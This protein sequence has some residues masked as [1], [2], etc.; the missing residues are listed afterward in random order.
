MG[1]S[2]TR[3]RTHVSCTSRQIL[4]HWV[5]REAPRICLDPQGSETERGTLVCTHSKHPSWPAH[6]LFSVPRFTVVAPSP[7]L[8]FCIIWWLLTACQ[9]LYK[10]LSVFLILKITLQRRISGLFVRLFTC[11]HTKEEGKG[12]EVQGGGLGASTVLHSTNAYWMPKMCQTLSQAWSSHGEPEKELGSSTE[13]WSSNKQLYQPAMSI[14]TGKQ[15]EE[16]WIYVN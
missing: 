5:T 10:V 11:E 16:K 2:W 14:M 4:D 9:E 1:Y 8:F 7:C 6:L 12:K 15:G 3:D 13:D